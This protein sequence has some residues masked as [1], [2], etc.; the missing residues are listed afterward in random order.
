MSGR[1]WEHINEKMDL[2]N[3]F[4]DVENTKGPSVKGDGCYRQK[5]WQFMSPTSNNFGYI[6]V[7]GGF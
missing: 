3:Q 4:I 5:V 1:F 7:G 6:A 2:G